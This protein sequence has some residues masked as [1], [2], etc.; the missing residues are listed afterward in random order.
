[1]KPDAHCTNGS[2]TYV[3]D[4]QLNMRS[5]KELVRPVERAKKLSDL[6]ARDLEVPGVGPNLRGHTKKKSHDIMLR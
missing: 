1:M 5:L 3:P 4:C 6:I 2:K